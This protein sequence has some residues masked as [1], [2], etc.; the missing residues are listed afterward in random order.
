Y[1]GTLG[2]K[3]PAYG[4]RYTVTINET[5]MASCTILFMVEHRIYCISFSAQT[6]T[7]LFPYGVAFLEQLHF[8]E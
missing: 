4:F 6:E 5:E 8:A 1:T 2:E 7:D 3:T